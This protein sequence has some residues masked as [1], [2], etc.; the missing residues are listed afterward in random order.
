MTLPQIFRYCIVVFN[1]IEDFY[2]SHHRAKL[3][4]V[5]TREERIKFHLLLLYASYKMR[6]TYINI[7]IIQETG[8]RIYKSFSNKNININQ[9]AVKTG[10]VRRPYTTNL[11]R[12][13]QTTYLLIC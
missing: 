5:E 10:L 8:Y 6:I 11:T 1:I 9:Q 7:A 13:I 12:F 3:K 4:S 2:Q